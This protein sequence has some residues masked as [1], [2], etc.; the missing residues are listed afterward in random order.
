MRGRLPLL[1]QWP[2]AATVVLRWTGQDPQGHTDPECGSPTPVGGGGPTHPGVPPPRCPCRQRTDTGRDLLCALRG[3]GRRAE[4]SDEDHPAVKPHITITSSETATANPPAFDDVCSDN[5]LPRFQKLEGISA[6]LVEVSLTDHKLLLNT[7]QRNRVLD[8][9]N[10]VEEHYKQPQKYHQLYRTHS[11]NTYCLTKRDDLAD[12]A[13][14]QRVKLAKRYAAAQQD[15]SLQCNRLYVLV[16]L[17]WLHSHEASR[18]SPEKTSL[19]KAYDRIQHRVLVEDPILCKAGLPLPKINTKTVRDFIRQQERLVNLH[20]IRQPAVIPKN[21]SV[22]SEELPPA[23]RQPAI[24]P[25]PDYPLL[26]YVPTPDGTIC[27][28]QCH[29]ILLSHHCLC[30]EGMH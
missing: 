12:A 17:L 6:V 4:M 23:R 27:R 20:A 3:G 7:E 28:W 29:S 11:G 13:V 2:W 21:S 8:T 15:I 9:W 16:K 19:L 22:S 24:L 26:E 30:I 5:P 18:S 10:A 14:V 25:P 1:W